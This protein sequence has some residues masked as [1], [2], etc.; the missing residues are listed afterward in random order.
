MEFDYGDEEMMSRLAKVVIGRDG[1]PIIRFGQAEYTAVVLGRM[2]TMRSTTLDVLE[3]F[4]AAG[5]SVIFAGDPP[6][7]VN[8]IRNPDACK[9]ASRAINVAWNQTAVVHA[10]RSANKIRVEM[11]DSDGGIASHIFCQ[12]RCDQLGNI[13]IVVLNTD[14]AH[15]ISGAKMRLIGVNENVKMAE[16]DCATSQ[17]ICLLV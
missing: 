8:A 10:C 5:G 1:K 15:G 12:L 16:W 13:I 9:L 6:E 7:Y 4:R 17:A 2:T 3:Q 11:T 14:R